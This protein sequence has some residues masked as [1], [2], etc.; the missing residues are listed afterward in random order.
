[1]TALLLACQELQPPKQ[2]ESVMLDM[3]TSGLL[4]GSI[5]C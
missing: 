4:M 3:D 5:H 2:H 1:V